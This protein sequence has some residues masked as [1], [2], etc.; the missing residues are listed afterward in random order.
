MMIKIQL[1]SRG[2]IIREIEHKDIK[3]KKKANKLLSKIYKMLKLE[4]GIHPD[5]CE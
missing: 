2:K 4:I 1:I 5:F 3:T